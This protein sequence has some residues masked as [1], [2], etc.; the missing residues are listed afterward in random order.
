MWRHFCEPPSQAGPRHFIIATQGG[1]VKGSNAF[2]AI[3]GLQSTPPPNSL[4]CR[5]PLQLHAATRY[6]AIPPTELGAQQGLRRII[7]AE[8]VFRDS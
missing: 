6:N 1:A 7:R 8:G 4:L 3:C 5:H 2:T